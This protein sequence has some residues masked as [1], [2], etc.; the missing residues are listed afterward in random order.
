MTE[1]RMGG[2]AFPES[3]P[4]LDQRTP[5]WIGGGATVWDM[6][7][8]AALS[9]APRTRHGGTSEIEHVTEIAAAI[10]DQMIT[11]RNKRMEGRS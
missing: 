1:Q 8:A 6:Y 11:E 5:G 3:Y 9:N 7:A 2:P 10:A 4:G